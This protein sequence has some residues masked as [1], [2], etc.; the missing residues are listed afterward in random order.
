MLNASVN[1]LI[2]KEIGCLKIL[3][4][5]E[6][7]PNNLEPSDLNLL[8]K[9]IETHKQ[10]NEKLYICKCKKCEKTYFLPEIELLKFKR[11]R[12]C[13]DDNCYD[14]EII[15]KCNN[16]D[17]DY[18]NS[19]HESLIIQKCVDDYYIYHS[20]PENNKEIKKRIM[21]TKICKR[22]ICKCYL[23]DKEYIF[24]STDFEIKSDEYGRN[25]T[26]GY[27]SNACCPCHPLSSFQWRTIKIFKKYNINYR[28]EYFFP[29]L[30]GSN[31]LNL[32]KFDFAIFNSDGSLKCLVEC[33]GEQHYTPVSEFGG[34]HAFTFQQKN[35]KLKR[36]Y[37]VR[38]NI[39][40]IEIPYTCKTLEQELKN[41]NII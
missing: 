16:Y 9:E 30:L 32:L 22:Y 25:A 31:G 19:I 10:I 5:S 15:E 26:K 36:D 23:C 12:Y 38:K 34:E 13:N 28:V 17:V 11:K 3:G 29:D 14:K 6:H 8:K 41:N 40:L 1:Q 24:N 33:Q 4:D 2:G 39:P 7:Y 18:T 20:W 21:H 35:D 27:Y 37:A